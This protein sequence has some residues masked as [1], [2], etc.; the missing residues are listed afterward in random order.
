MKISPTR[1]SALLLG[2][3]FPSIATADERTLTPEQMEALA[4]AGDLVG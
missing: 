4:K 3:L 1:F 2:I